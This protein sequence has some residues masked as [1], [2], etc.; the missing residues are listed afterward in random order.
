MTPISAWKTK[1]TKVYLNKIKNI[2]SHHWCCWNDSTH[3]SNIKLQSTKQHKN[4]NDYMRVEWGWS[5]EVVQRRNTEKWTK[6]MQT[7][8]WSCEVVQRR[9][10]AGRTLCVRLNG[11]NDE[12]YVK[13]S[14][15]TVVLTQMSSRVRRRR[16]TFPQKL[17]WLHIKVKLFLILFF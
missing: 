15:T 12:S 14:S 11:K 8:T 16:R 3:Y 10:G 6:T 5:C 9:Q 4:W 7:R 1:E 2:S 13:S 17:F